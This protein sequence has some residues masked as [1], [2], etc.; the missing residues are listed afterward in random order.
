MAFA[1][2]GRGIAI[3][4]E[5]LGQRRAAVG[6]Q[7]VVAR[8]RGGHL[9]DRP[10]SHRVV[11]A[12]GEQGR[13]G[14]RAQGGGVKAVVLEALGGQPLGGG[15]VHGA[16]EGGGGAETD[17][18]KQHNQHVGGA[19]GGAQGLNRRVVGVWILGIKSGKPLLLPVGNRKHGAGQIL[20]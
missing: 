7:G 5:Q 10:K 20:S 3:Q 2:L 12:A 1:E 19:G 16:A 14:G 6:P 9:G 17:V 11:V 15:G 8:R 18:I 13:P 4:L